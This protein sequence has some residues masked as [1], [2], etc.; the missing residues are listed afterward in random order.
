MELAQG[1]LFQVRIQLKYNNICKTCRYD[2][3]SVRCRAFVV[4]L[5]FISCTPAVHHLS[6]CCSPYLLLLRLSSSSCSSFVLL[7]L[8]YSS[9]AFHLRTLGRLQDALERH[10]PVPHKLTLFKHNS[11]PISEFFSRDVSWS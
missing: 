11:R 6:P 7:K 5:L 9:S 10:T 1:Y 2:V 4:P 8:P 3:F